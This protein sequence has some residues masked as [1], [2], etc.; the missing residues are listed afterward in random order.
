MHMDHL[1]IGV[2][3]CGLRAGKSKVTIEIKPF[4]HSTFE[5]I[6]AITKLTYSLRQDQ[7]IIWSIRAERLG[8]FTTFRTSTQKHHKDNHNYHNFNNC[9]YQY[10]ANF[11]FR[12]IEFVR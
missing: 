11:G 7:F 3:D 2:L 10:D 4:E 12:N 8:S 5:Q 9:Q 1:E 6:I